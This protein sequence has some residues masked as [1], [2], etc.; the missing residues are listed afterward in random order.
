MNRF[1]FVCIGLSIALLSGVLAACS[2][3]PSDPTQGGAAPDILTTSTIL[4]DVARNVAGDRLTVEALLPAGA[5]PHSYQPTPQDTARISQSK[6]LVVNGAEYEHFLESLL[7]NADGERM[8]IEASAGLRLRSDPENGHGVDPHLWLD[9]NHMIGY[10]EN[11][12]EGLIRFDPQGAE[13]YRSNAEAYIEQLEE[14]DAWINA[15]IAQIP[16]ARRLLVTNHEAFGYFAERYDFTIVGTV[17]ESFSSDASPSAQQMAALVDQIKLHEAP[18]IF[19][20]ASDNPALA[21]Q[22]AKETGAQVVTDLHLE[23]L[24]EDAPAPTY[25][26]MMKYNVTKIVEALK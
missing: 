11:I 1:A 8:L 12:R 16:P 15:Q 3:T 24:T 19:L 25:I 14:L 7:E 6:V 21:Q 22:V 9:P 4:A 23:S 18:A 2:G 17:I 20:D 5:D 13:I 10:V 26:E